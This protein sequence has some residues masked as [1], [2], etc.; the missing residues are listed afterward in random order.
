MDV[1][2]QVERAKQIL[3]DFVD[4][5]V[6]Y[7]DSLGV[8]AMIGWALLIFGSVLFVIGAILLAA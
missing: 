6:A 5:A 2:E 3:A 8:Y 7:F 1:D 4:A